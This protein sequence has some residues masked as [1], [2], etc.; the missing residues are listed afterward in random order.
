MHNIR[1]HAR[2]Y[3]FVYVSGLQYTFID[4]NWYS[5]SQYERT[6]LHYACKNGHHDTVKVLLERGV[7]LN[8]HDKVCGVQIMYEL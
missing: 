3:S 1:I 2:L 6:A 8:T 4:V 7:D 5:S